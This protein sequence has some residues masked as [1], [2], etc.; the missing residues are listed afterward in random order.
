MSARRVHQAR[1]ALMM[2]TRLPVGRLPEP[3]PS[4]A[5]AS[6]AFPLVGLIVGGIGWGALAIAVVLG[7]PPLTASF[8]AIAAMVLVTGALHHDGLADFADGIGGGRDLTHCLDI[9]RDSR[10]GSYGVVALILVVG[11]QA[12]ALSEFGESDR[13]PGSTLIAFLFLAVASRVMMVALLVWLPPARSDGLGVMAAGP[14]PTALVPGGGVCVALGIVLGSGAI[15]AALAMCLVAF[16]MARLALRRIKGQTGDVLG[17]AQ[18]TSEVV[19]WV[20]LSVVIS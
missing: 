9:M 8:A 19:G 12:S 7:L 6:W 16:G 17:A 4:L 11:L 3:A 5:D 18:M 14:S 2:L 15:V 10:I 1:L 13:L 20:A